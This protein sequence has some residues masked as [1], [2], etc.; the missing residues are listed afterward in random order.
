MATPDHIAFPVTAQTAAA[1]AFG[2]PAAGWV[3][4]WADAVTVTSSSSAKFVILSDKFPVGKVI[5][6]NIGANG[7]KLGTPAGSS[8]TINNVDT[9][10]GTA[11]AAIPANTTALIIR[12]LTTGFLLTNYTNLGAVATAIV[13]S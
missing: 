2:G 11:S 5:M 9:S 8:L 13:P 3:P 4:E 1:T 7:Y 10:G 6:V 12:S